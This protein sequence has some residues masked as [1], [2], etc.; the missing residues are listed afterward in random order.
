M[1]FSPL[2][3]NR[4]RQLTVN[5]MC[6]SAALRRALLKFLVQSPSQNLVA[7]IEGGKG[8]EGV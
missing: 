7:D 8:A 6:Y 4:S 2:Y 3:F 5:K 1:R